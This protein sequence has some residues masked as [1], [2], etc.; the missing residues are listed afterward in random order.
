[1]KISCFTCLA[2]VFLLPT[3]AHA[4][5]LNAS[6][7][8]VTDSLAGISD[9][10]LLVNG[11]TRYRPD[12]DL[13]P[14][15]AVENQLR[16]TSLDEVFLK[17]T[18]K[19]G[20]TPDL[21][22]LI[23]IRYG[24]AFDATDE[25]V[26]KP[27]NQKIYS[28]IVG[29]D[30]MVWYGLEDRAD[31]GQTTVLTDS[32]WTFTVAGDD[33]VAEVFFFIS[34]HSN[35]AS[36]MPDL[37]PL[38]YN[39]LYLLPEPTSQLFTEATDG[40]VQGKPLQ[41]AQKLIVLVHGWNPADYSN[42]FA[43]DNEDKPDD[44]D[45]K[46]LS[47]RW[48][49]L[50]SNLIESTVVQQ[51]GW[52]VARYDWSRD[53]NAGLTHPR[54]AMDAA[55]A[56]GAKLGQL[57]RNAGATRVQFIAHSAG[58]W[59]ARRAAAYLKLKNPSIQIQITSLDPYVTDDLQPAYELTS[60]WTTILDNFYVVD[61]ATDAFHWTSGDFTGWNNHNIEYLVIFGLYEPWMNDH[62]GPVSWYAKTAK[63]VNLGKSGFE[64]GFITS[65]AARLASRVNDDFPGQALAGESGSALWFNYQATA[66]PS[67]PR[68][69]SFV[70]ARRSV[71]G[72]WTAPASGT[73]TFDTFGADFNA[74]LAAYTGGSLSSLTQIASDTRGQ[75]GR[76]QCQISFPAVAGQTYYIAVDQ[77]AD[78]IR[79]DGQSPLHWSMSGGGGPAPAVSITAPAAGV[80]INNVITVN[81]NASSAT[82]VEFYLDA[83]RQ[84]TDS[85]APFTW[86]WNTA[87]AANMPHILSVKSYSGTV[88][89]AT[90]ANVPVTVNNPSTP[91]PE[92]VDPS[93][94]N[95]S[96]PTATPLA[97]AAAASGYICTATDVDWFKVV[98][99]AP[100]VL[101]F[102]LTVPAANDYD[103]ELFGPD[104][105]YIS[106]SYR[107]TGLAENI[108]HNATVI[109]TYYVRVY[110]YPLGSGSY[111]ATKP[112]GLMA[113]FVTGPPVPNMAVIPAGS[114]QM[115]DSFNEGI[116]DEVPTHSVY[117]SAFY[118]DRY[119]VT[120]ALWDEV[121]QWAVL[122]GYAFDNSGGGKAANHPVVLINW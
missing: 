115:G 19:P 21:N 112:Y 23:E 47:P 76:G 24:N 69:D 111:D 28:R 31:F 117:V 100:G 68:H 29:Q 20:V 33:P 27:G 74:V 42:K 79:E 63:D 61:L 73:A 92:C 15:G 64:A 91:S 106:G 101:S 43:P 75:N 71:W 35:V 70:P 98:V 113:N 6:H 9:T 103:L 60:L 110:G 36:E 120:K 59:A 109:G 66:Q 89:L 34:H 41:S 88:L 96:S 99:S 13:S 119:E 72:R 102:D 122:R 84:F 37:L 22:K 58:N 2:L 17:I 87:T 90:S 49:Q 25:F 78:I 80:T 54:N 81:A 118:M 62:A 30:L 44:S 45:E 7:F 11:N 97:L 10:K 121:Y 77:A 55:I 104:A 26:F 53:A 18:F 52:T 95:N 5:G 93:E 85:A 83:V 12:L 38:N 82:K 3:L 56:H 108:T 1:M 16:N 8:S 32:R 46:K 57:V 67:E 105:A 48:A 4:T 107:D 50:A 116:S 65:L 39:H 51:F 114:F 86:A 94:P 14:N 40:H